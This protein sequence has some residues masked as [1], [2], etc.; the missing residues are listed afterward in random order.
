M[1]DIAPL[2][3]APLGQWI[4][5]VTAG[6]MVEARYRLGWRNKDGQVIASKIEGWLPNEPTEN[7]NE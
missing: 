1:A 3:S 6:R 5:V 4:I 2:S 7:R